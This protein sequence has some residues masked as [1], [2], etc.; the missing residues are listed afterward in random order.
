MIQRQRL[1]D[2]FL[3]L[4]QVDSETLFER[5]IADVLKKKLV[6]LGMD[7][8]EDSSSPRTGHAAGN[9]VAT[10]KGS[11]SDVPVIYFT[12]HM[13]TVAPGKGIKPHIDGEYIKSDGTTILG[14]DDKAGLAAMLEGIR[15]LKEQNIEHGDL[16][17]VIT[18]GEES[19]LN[20]ARHLDR[21]LVKAKY[22][23]AFDSNGL[24][25][26][27]VVSAPT[28]A[29]LA[30][31]I[32]GRS[33]HAG[34]A[35]E[36]GISAI[37]VASKAISR[38]P[39]GRIDAE[40]TANIG[41]FEG[42]G[43]TNIVTE[44]VGILAEARSLDNEKLDRQVEAMRQALQSATEEFG[45]RFEL[46]VN[47]LYPSY[48]YDESDPVVQLAMEAARK[49]GRGPSLH[50]SGGGSDANV[51]NGYGI[52]TVN[53]AIGYEHIHTTQEQMPISELVK[54]AELFVAIVRESVEV[55]P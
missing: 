7:V 28:Q 6:E 37:Q 15:V 44:R 14:S 13:D 26:E 43:P 31:T 22:G 21:E 20:G 9:L 48:K 50:S 47:K 39:L 55:H 3:E 24:V 11:H 17:L 32:F 42:G 25:G 52:P 5:E 33:A 46:E 40:T 16:Q 35:P 34:V 4:V 30:I 12:S 54:A 41:R 38:M 45:A 36:K 18:A 49:I 23:Y 27:I 29:K 2:E 1:I 53:L 8:V 10:L 51:M 19:G